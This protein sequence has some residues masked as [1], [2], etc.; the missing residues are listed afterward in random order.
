MSGS[1]IAIALALGIALLVN[2]PIRGRALYRAAI[3]L[4]Y[5]LMAVAV[6]IIWRWLYDEKV[7]L[8]NFV[9]MSLGLV[10]QRHP[11]PRARSSGRC[12]RSSWR[13]SGRSSAS[14]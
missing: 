12:P 11:L 7:G 13:P 1:A 2:R 10:S 8:L 14:S 4:S 3:F 6:G 9:L 5:P